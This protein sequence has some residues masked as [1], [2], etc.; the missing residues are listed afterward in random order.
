MSNNNSYQKGIELVKEAA[1]KD[2]AEEYETAIKLYLQALE[3]FMH[4]IKYDKNERTKKTVREKIVAY[5]K[6]AEQLKKFVADREEAK[7]NP[8]KGKKATTSGG[9]GD[10]DEED[11]DTKQLRHMLE[12]V[13]KV[14]QPN[15]HWDDVAG[16]D[17]VKGQLKEAV[18]MPL[19]MPHLFTNGRSPWAGILMFGPPGTGKSFLAKAV[20]TEANDSTFMAASSADLVSKWQGQ[21]E[22]LVKEL[23]KMAREKSPCIIFVD[24]VDSLCGARGEGES[25]SSRRIKTEF[26]VQMQGVGSNNKGLLVLGAT[27]IPWQLDNAIR[28]RFEKRVYIPLPDVVARTKIFQLNMGKIRH[29]LTENDW[30]ELGRASEGRSGADITVLCK[31]AIMAPIRKLQSATHFCQVE[32]P[33]RETPEI[34]RQYWTPCSPGQAGAQEMNWLSFED[35]KTII[36]GAV[37]MNDMR[38]CM[39]NNKA[40][41][42]PDDLT[43][44]D[45]WA[46]QFGQEG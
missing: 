26:L 10:D 6:R 29:K 43:E 14:E 19:R 2:G 46:E 20:A 44:L 37:D 42:S 17:V 5:L 11:A 21:S 34:T 15:V 12:Q 32:A 33:D 35:P 38:R 3:H 36:E 30:K 45:M 41:V 24:E 25:E 1:A 22:R 7:K 28:R 8:G 31:D 23:F 40:T 4:F 13:V 18:I 39:K 9:G 27:N 16:L